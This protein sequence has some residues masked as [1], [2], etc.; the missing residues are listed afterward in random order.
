ML[1][2]V[3]SNEGDPDGPSPTPPQ[4]PLGASLST[5]VVDPNTIMFALM[6]EYISTC[7]YTDYAEMATN[8][9]VVLYR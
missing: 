5:S 9:S 3:E 2:P 7:F 6:R 1:Q 8:I 4:V